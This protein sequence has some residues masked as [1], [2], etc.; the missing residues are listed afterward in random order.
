VAL[1]R[2]GRNLVR[3]TI[4]TTALIPSVADARTRARESLAEGT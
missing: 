4:G 1:Y 2:V 3:E